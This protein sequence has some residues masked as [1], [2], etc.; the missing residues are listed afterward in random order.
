MKYKDNFRHMKGGR[1]K[2]NNK[3]PQPISFHERQEKLRE[4]QE[5]I[6]RKNFLESIYRIDKHWTKTLSEEE[7][8]DLFSSWSWNKSIR[9]MVKESDDPSSL[10]FNGEE[11]DG[12]YETIRDFVK[13]KKPY[14]GNHIK[15]R[16]L[17]IDD[18]FSE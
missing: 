6:F 7:I 1:D 10:W 16:E 17:K 2:Y 15:E 13:A 3:I 12:S 8:E 4:K 14:Y 18:L 5:K 9:K 11:G